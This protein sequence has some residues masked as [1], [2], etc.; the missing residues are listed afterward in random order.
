MNIKNADIEAILEAKEKNQLVVFI[1][2]GVSANS[3]LPSWGE[4][5]NN[6]AKRLGINRTLSSEDYLRIP[7]YFYNERNKLEYYQL[8][9]SVFAGK[10][11]P[12]ILHDQL[13]SLNP[14]HI[15]TTNY[16]DLIE[17]ALE[18]HY[19]FYNKVVEDKDLPYAANN[20]LYIKMHGDIL[21]KNIVL[22]E[23]D[24]LNYSRDFRL[25]E[26]YI[27]SIFINH[28]VLF[29]GYSV[30]DYDLKLII[31]RLQSTIGNDFRTAYLLNAS[32]NIDNFERSYFKKF[33][34]NIIDINC[35]PNSYE[36]R[37]RLE[38]SF[39]NN[40]SNLLD[41]IN[42][43]EADDKNSLDYFVEKWSS[44]K[45]VYAVRVSDLFQKLN[46]TNISYEFNDHHLQITLHPSFTEHL[47]I[48]GFIIEMNSIKKDLE[49][50]LSNSQINNY[51]YIQEV[52]SKADI[53]TI[54]VI[55]RGNN[56]KR[57]IETFEVKTKEED[58]KP[59]VVKHI[60]D[61]SYVELENTI[62]EI[63]LRNPN[64]S[65]FENLSL[66]YA[67]AHLNQFVSA[68]EQLKNISLKAY[69]EKKYNMYYLS[70]FNKLVITKLLKSP[71]ML[72]S[73][74]LA[75][76]FSQEYINELKSVIE[77]NTEIRESFNQL[78][79]SEKESFK[80]LDDLLN[81]KGLL[82][83]L[84]TKTRKISEKIRN[85]IDTHFIFGSQDIDL[86]KLVSSVHEFYRYS[87]YNLLITNYY[88]ETK[89]IYKNYF[90]AICCTYLNIEKAKEIRDKGTSIIEPYQFTHRDLIII[91]NCLSEDEI[92]KIIESY[93][94]NL[95]LLSD[96]NVFYARL[97]LFNLISSYS[98]YTKSRN[99]ENKLCATLTLFKYIEFPVESLEEII[100]KFNGI[101]SVRPIRDSVYK[102]FINFVLSQ[103]KIENV[104]PKLFKIFIEN[105]LKKLANNEWNKET[106]FEMEFLK[107]FNFITQ[108]FEITSIKNLKR[109]QWELNPVFKEIDYSYLH[110][111]RRELYL[112]FSELYLISDD[113]FKKLFKKR[114]KR[115]LKEA[116]NVGLFLRA[117][118]LNIV[119]PQKDT[120]NSFSNSLKN[121]NS[122]DKNDIIE[123]VIFSK[124]RPKS[125]IKCIKSINK[126]YTFLVEQENYD[127]KNN[128]F[129]V[130][131]LYNI[132][133]EQLNNFKGSFYKFIQDKIKKQ[134]LISNFKDQNLIQLYF[135]WFAKE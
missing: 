102:A 66:S 6:F 59:K 44:F 14:K 113:I 18:K 127:Y 41:Y 101:I 108:L 32:P 63:K 126:F 123:F 86:P 81:S 2:A 135:K 105:Y 28:T 131:W 65:Y 37:N 33:G 35:I 69:K 106:G 125:I 54:T 76:P 124:N 20:R 93:D 110:N 91:T 55:K 23:D 88:S 99:I 74:H 29:I 84:R 130:K 25:I 132:P 129:E 78:T 15:I 107:T 118:E 7:Q 45:D 21:K 9:E 67:Y 13:L 71:A 80:Y 114:I 64:L 104:D 87:T 82:D 46:I 1:G 98:R 50:S 115:Y 134:I 5:V 94:I 53:K 57:E 62:N 112:I 58:W 49:E 85:N 42:S 103:S 96:S 128:P 43:Y 90:N 75:E 92:E 72:L 48:M 30:Q 133:D 10:Y 40:V 79:S 22:K 73:G 89:E 36:K 83:D 117:V 31:K 8:I 77:M 26:N 17:Q 122:R 70:N 11:S 119:I 109:V 27:E 38:N 68:N 39:G 95:I 61:N 19:L 52:L 47:F 16:D 111:Y 100:K 51:M 56:F 116:F 3:G 4:L 121:L 97:L 12:N 34:I 24:Y 60:E 120:L